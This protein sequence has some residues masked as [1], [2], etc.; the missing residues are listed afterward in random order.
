[1]REIAL[2]ADLVLLHIHSRRSYERE[3]KGREG[4]LKEL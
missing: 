2:R 1:M 3:L 4:R